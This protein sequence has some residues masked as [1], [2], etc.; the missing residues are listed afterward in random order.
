MRSLYL[1][2][3]ACL[4]CVLCGAAEALLTAPPK[5]AKSGDATTITFNVLKSTYVEVAVL[6]AKGEVVRHLAAGALASPTAAC[7]RLT[8]A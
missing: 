2:S 3:I 6:N 5:A 1:A 4:S 8:A 7:L